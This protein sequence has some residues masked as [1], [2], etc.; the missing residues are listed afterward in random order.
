MRS[1]V[2]GEG[3][4]RLVR[5]QVALGP[6]VPGSDAHAE[7]GRRLRAALEE[8]SAEVTVQEFSLPFRGRTLECR[9]IVGVFR[10][11][12]AG[13]GPLLLGSHYDCRFRADR[14]KDPSRRESP[15]PGA[16]DGG[17]GTAVLLQLPLSAATRFAGVPQ[18]ETSAR[19][20]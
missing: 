15:I 10:A 7:L 20:R 2:D 11:R 3:I 12:R 16:N 18:L 9:N 14:E 8:A 4:L 17:S 13:L 19:R 6:R 5:E 1:P